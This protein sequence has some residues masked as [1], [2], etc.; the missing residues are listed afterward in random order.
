ML[1]KVKLLYSTILW[2]FCMED[3][4]AYKNFKHINCEVTVF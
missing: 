4:V 3:A 1:H 2:Q